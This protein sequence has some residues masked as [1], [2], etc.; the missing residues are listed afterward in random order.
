MDSPTAAEPLRLAFVHWLILGW[1]TM[2]A[3]GAVYQLISVVLQRDVFS[4]RLGY[5]QFGVYF[6]GSSACWPDSASSGCSGSPCLPHWPCWASCCL[7]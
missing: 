2:I 7:S 5:I 6:A 3:M 1:A 4:R